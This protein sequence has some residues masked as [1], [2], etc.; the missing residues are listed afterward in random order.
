MKD[1]QEWKEAPLDCVLLSMYQL[2]AF[3]YNEIKRG[4][5]GLGEYT[6]ALQYTALKLGE[7]S[8]T[9]IPTRSPDEIVKSIKDGTIAETKE[10]YIDKVNNLSIPCP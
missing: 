7:S 3:Y 10:C 1:I 6:I 2:Q 8:L 5:A 4:L 9:Y